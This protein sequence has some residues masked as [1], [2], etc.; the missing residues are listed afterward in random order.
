[1]TKCVYSLV[2]LRALHVVG[3]EETVLLHSSVTVPMIGRDRTV[4]KVIRLVP[5]NTRQIKKNVTDLVC[6]FPF[7]CL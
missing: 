6:L 4:K 5:I 3:M 2:Q 1:M 7:S